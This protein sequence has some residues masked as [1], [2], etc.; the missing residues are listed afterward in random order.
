MVEYFP[1]KLPIVVTA[2]EGTQAGIDDWFLRNKNIKNK[3]AHQDE[4]YTLRYRTGMLLGCDLNNII[5]EKDKNVN[6]YMDFIYLNNRLQK[7]L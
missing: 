3:K 2:F 5:Q 4:G 6:T 7:Y 1:K